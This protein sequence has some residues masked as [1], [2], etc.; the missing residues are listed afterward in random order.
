MDAMNNNLINLK[1]LEKISNFFNSSSNLLKQD[2][3]SICNKYGGIDAINE[4]AKNASQESSKIEKLKKL[5]SPYLKDI[6]WLLEMKKSNAFISLE[7]YKKNI[8]KNEYKKLIINKDN[9]ITLEISTLQF[10]PWFIAQ[11][12]RA[13]EKKTLMPCRYI[14]VRNMKEQENDLGDLI[15]VSLAMDI[16]GA[17]WVETLDTKGLDGSNIHIDGT[18]TIAGYLGGIGQPNTNALKWIDELLYYHTN[19]GIKEFLN[20]NSGTILLALILH[21]LGVNIGFK[22]SVFMGNDNPYSVLSTLMIAKMLSREDDST[23]LFG[24]NFSNSVNNDTIKTCS[25]YRKALGLENKIRFEHHIT[26]SY[27]HI[28][29]QPYYRL[30]ELISIAKEVKNISAKHEGGIP[31]L[32]AEKEIPSGVFDYFMSKND[33]IKNNLMEKMEND[34]LDKHDALTIT[35]EELIKNGIDVIPAQNLH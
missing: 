35:A 5:N 17:T 27:Q 21:K 30:N 14:R 34:Y 19:Y 23:A 29:R 4:K 25:E 2:L 11:A 32:E 20:I 8:L 24:L 22:I 1:N 16:I 7:E 6:E 9:S 13:I 15:A 12:K 18:N 10:F 3:L 31:Y 28:V 26:E 33:I